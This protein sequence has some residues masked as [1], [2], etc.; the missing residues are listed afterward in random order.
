ME[1]SIS[2]GSKVAIGTHLGLN[3]VERIVMCRVVGVTK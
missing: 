3:Y 1:G 2:T